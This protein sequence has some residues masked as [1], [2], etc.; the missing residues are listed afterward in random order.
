MTCGFS[1]HL[2]SD[3]RRVLSTGSIT[4]RRPGLPARSYAKV[5]LVTGLCLEADYR[6][7]VQWLAAV[8]GSERAVAGEREARR[9]RIAIGRVPPYCRV[10]RT[11][12]CF[13][14]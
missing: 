12:S 14:R 8:P 4:G 11:K 9:R 5:V 13:R 10:R 3:I 7:V 2:S 1:G 6:H